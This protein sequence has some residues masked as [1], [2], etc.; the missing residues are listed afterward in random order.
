MI[1]TILFIIAILLFLNGHWIWGIIALFAWLMWLGRDGAKTNKTRTRSHAP[2][3]YMN[4]TA[5]RTTGYD[6][7]DQSLRDQRDQPSRETD[8]TYGISD[9]QLYY[10]LH[11][12]IASVKGLPGS[13]L[14]DSG[15]DQARQWSGQ[16]GERSIAKALLASGVMDRPDVRV[17]YSLRNPNDE[18]GDAD[19]DIVLAHGRVVYL[20]DAKHYSPDGF[21]ETLQCPNLNG[22]YESAPWTLLTTGGKAYKASGNMM[23]AKQSIGR[24]LGPTVDLQAYVLLARTAHG[25]PGTQKGTRWP[26][27]IHARNADNWIRELLME[28]R[29]EPS[30]PVP[31]QINDY[32]DGLVKDSEWEQRKPG[33]RATRTV[34]QL[35]GGKHKGNASRSIRE[36]DDPQPAMNASSKT[37]PDS[38]EREESKPEHDTAAHA[39]AIAVPAASGIPETTGS[40]ELA[41]NIPVIRLPGLP[42]IADTEKEGWWM[43]GHTDLKW[44][45]QPGSKASGETDDT[46]GIDD[47]DL[48]ALLSDCKAKVVGLPCDRRDDGDGDMR[49]GAG[50]AKAMLHH[51]LLDHGNVRVW[52][53]VNNPLEGA[54]GVGVDAIVVYDDQ[55]IL[56]DLKYCEPSRT[57]GLLTCPPVVTRTQAAPWELR[58]DDGKSYPASRNLGWTRYAV[59]LLLKD[60]NCTQVDAVALLARTPH[61]IPATQQGTRW[62]GDA[63]ARPIDQWMAWRAAQFERGFASKPVDPRVVDRINRIC[64]YKA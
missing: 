29:A 47:A 55:V 3:P 10:L 4:T 37:E 23:W 21:G 5:E 57:G 13:G 18:S 17:W 2:T 27:D 1:A 7:Q 53:D 33:E 56:L 48:P 43:T 38:A 40:V 36:T 41:P 52:F 63:F 44:A 8:G 22:R 11:N 39:D 9:K 28:L 49:G 12:C 19:I 14:S 51:G 15:F 16:A 42:V 59:R 46:Y 31:D 35:L 50:L 26:G 58:T 62:P 20:L 6:P 34:A 54:G 30:M 45:M 25:V 64:R 60:L 61:G 24:D 32:F